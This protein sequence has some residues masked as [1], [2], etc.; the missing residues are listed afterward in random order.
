MKKNELN[1]KTLKE[2]LESIQNPENLDSHI[3]TKSLFVQDIIANK[4]NL[5]EQNSGSQ[6]LIAIAELFRQMMPVS[7]PK[8]GLRLDARWSEFG[9]LAAKYFSPIL[10]GHPLP[11]SFQDAWERIDQSILLFVYG[12]TKTEL[13]SE[14]IEP[15]V[16][17][18]NEPDITPVSTLSDWH[19]KG[20]QRLLELIQA[21]ENHLAISPSAA[22]AKPKDTPASAAQK[23]TGKRIFRWVLS[24]LI[25]GSFL[26]G[27]MKAWR[28][29]QT[30]ILVYEDVLQLKGDMDSLP[31]LTELHAVGSL[32]EV[33]QEDLDV[34]RYEVDPL[35]WLSPYMS[36]VPRYGGELASARELL[37]MSEFLIDSSVESFQ[38]GQPLLQVFE[39]DRTELNP[40][41]LTELL[42]QAQPQFS[43]AQISLDKARK[44]REG[45]NAD[46]LSPYMREVLVN[47]VDPL[48]ILMDDA[49]T[50]AVEFPNLV[51]AT[52][53]G[54]K[55]Y[56]LLVQNEDELRPTGG[57]ITAAGTILLQDGQLGNVKFE[58]S[59][60][61][62]NW[63]KLYP[64]APWQLRQYMNSPVLVFRDSNWSSDFPTS[65][66]Y[67]E[68]LYSYIYN[69]SVDGV[70]AFDQQM[71]VEIL[72]VLG[73]IELEDSP[74]PIDAGNVISYMRAEKTRNSEEDLANPNWSNKDFI[75]EIS[76]ALMTKIFEGDLP[77]EELAGVFIRTLDEHHLLLQLDNP[78]MTS[79][80]ARRGWDGTL[81]PG[82]GDFLMVVDSNIGFNKTNALIETSLIYDVDLTNLA[83]PISNLTVIHQNNA[84][85]KVPCVQWHGL[86]LEG[87]KDYP[88]DRCYWNY[89]RVYTAAGTSLQEAN[90]QAI[91]AD[92]MIRRQAV[93]AQVD[94]LEEEI[95]GVQG[96]GVLKVVPGDESVATNFQ[97]G[98]PVGIVRKQSGDGSM[99]YHLRIQK[100]PGTIAIPIIIRV[101][102]PN[103]TIIQTVP[104]G[105]VVQG[106]NILI[107]TSLR[108][109][110]EIEIIFQ[111]P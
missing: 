14:E 93:P 32:L 9:F 49:L 45:I 15:Y 66:L 10:F 16:L 19:R 36:W 58:N 85:S 77:W 75:N 54:P 89:M 70:I 59:G 28:I 57:F 18:G 98:L 64:A 101:H 109:D 8:H 26:V 30:G 34:F 31:E 96:F 65:A 56:L 7:P 88:V 22:Q 71:L 55:T 17:I 108:E 76:V 52:N 39:P 29:Y 23:R 60:D 3:W 5:K 68:F 50:V 21:R 47:K 73:P 41:V 27:G 44:A 99:I 43:S 6:L 33:L 46:S 63:E 11:A 42:V 105:A 80:L 97:F 4:P 35:L 81:Q 20:L 111:I 1:I 40:S 24:L 37:D 61:L 100:Q 12:K 72:M 90:P 110:R 106:D 84:D 69:H 48:L 94:I 62:D 67:A 25:I 102:F 107:E 13:S 2:I 104:A 78:S 95:D 92:W 91:P 83:A 51:G 86:T 103:A 82:E 53:E 87:Q 38:A 79:L 74:Y